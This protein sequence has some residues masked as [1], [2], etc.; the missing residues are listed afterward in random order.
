MKKS[1]V[2][3]WASDFEE[4]TGEGLLAR[5]F[6]K[7]ISKSNDC[8]FEVCSNNQLL[9]IYKNKLKIIEKNTYKNNFFFKYMMPFFGI[10]LIWK[11][12]LKGIK[13]LYLNYLPL[14][15]FLIFFLLPS[16][17]FLGPVTGGS[18][19]NKSS[20][21]NFF[22][23]KYIFNLLYILSINIIFF[24]HKK[25]FFSTD[26]LKKNIPKK[27][28]RNCIF[29]VSLIKY[30]QRKLKIKN[31][32]FLFYYKKHSN[33][34]FIFIKKLI[35]KIKKNY[36]VFVVGDRININGIK[37]IINIKQKKLFMLLDRTKYSIISGENFYSLFAID[38]ISS[39]VI[40]FYN[41]VIQP[42]NLIFNKKLIHPIDYDDIENSWLKIKK[43]MS[44]KKINLIKN[45]ILENK[46][47]KIKKKINFYYFFE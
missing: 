39:N 45:K 38:C 20:F 19:F 18:H 36:K 13:T 21:V 41:K 6:I 10:F 14:W 8:I 2:F 23:R 24:K 40:F 33:K 15:N 32:D 29:L 47:I 46:I 35:M 28:I 42:H 22:I 3:V 30:K 5:S 9:I 25:I 31:I 4:T 44:N 11:N 1:K 37:N 12:H 7:L 16:K 43:I 27:N 26:L 17:T 34:N